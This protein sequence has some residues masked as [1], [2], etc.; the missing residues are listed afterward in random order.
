M[1][2]QLHIYIYLFIYCNQYTDQDGFRDVLKGLWSVS[3]A[4]A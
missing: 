1:M 3:G 2:M 4:S